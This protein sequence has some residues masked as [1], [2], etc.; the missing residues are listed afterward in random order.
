[1]A[2]G[3]TATG[4]GLAE[5]WYVPTYVWPTIVANDWLIVPGKPV[6]VEGLQSAAATRWTS[7]RGQ[8]RQ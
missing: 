3:T 4:L 8:E 6:R 1:M 7:R 5:T 2:G